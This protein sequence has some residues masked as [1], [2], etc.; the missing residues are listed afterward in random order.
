LFVTK[1]NRIEFQDA[2]YQFSDIAGPK[3]PEK[4]PITGY[5]RRGIL[6]PVNRPPG[7]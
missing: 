5:V 3:R 7:S 4:M 2:I 1:R 6:G